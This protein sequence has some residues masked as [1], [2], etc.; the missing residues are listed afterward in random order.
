MPD[1]F[2]SFV[3]L[4]GM[5]TG[6][7]FLEES[8]NQY[9]GLKCFGEVFNPHFIG[10][11]GQTELLGYSLARR[12]TDPTGL[13]QEMNESL[14]GLAG[15]RHFFDHDARALDHVINDRSCAKVVLYRNPVESYVS[16]QIAR[17]TNQWRLGD[18]KNAKSAKIAFQP[19][20]FEIHFEQRQQFHNQIQTALQISGQGAYFIGYQDITDPEKIQGLAKYLGVNSEPKKRSG[21]TKK[22][23]PGTIEDKVSNYSEM[24]EY[25]SGTDYY[26]LS[27]MPV[28]EP[29]RGPSV[30][31]FL[32]SA[33]APVI[34][35]PLR[36]GPN[37]PVRRWLAEIGDG[38]RND[39]IGDFTQKTL[40]QWKRQ[41]KSHRSFTVVSHPVLRLHRA[42]AKHIWSSGPDSYPLIKESLINR[43]GITELADGEKAQQDQDL[44]KRAFMKFAKF[45]KGNL[46]GQSSIRVDG[47]WASQDVLLAG[48]ARFMVPDFVFREKDL[49]IGLNFVADNLAIA[50]NDLHAETDYSPVR[51]GDIY[52]EKLESA[53]RAAYQRDYMMYG[54]GAY[55]DEN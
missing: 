17:R 18:L 54:F 14:D 33:R 23:N 15:Y 55:S 50:P 47:S 41:N 22:Q 9:P 36:S 31:G 39:V 46:G 2:Q 13:L 29:D 6:S 1:R 5:R 38:S 49:S 7:N 8:L 48:I 11:A 43:Y 12:E 37:E 40:R 32:A 16:H 26:S 19:D 3:I 20:S 44:H 27:D 10:H 24:V 42:F 53:V 35:L 52:D 34:Y 25:L 21:K 28:F 51:L 30:P 45:I 4:A